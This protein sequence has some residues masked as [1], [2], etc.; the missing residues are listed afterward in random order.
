MQIDVNIK[1]TCK[2]STD[3]AFQYA[4]PMNVCTRVR[5]FLNVYE[6]ASRYEECPNVLEECS[7]KYV[8]WGTLDPHVASRNTRVA[9]VMN[10]YGIVHPCTS[11]VFVRKCLI[12]TKCEILSLYNI[13]VLHVQF[14]H[15]V[16][17]YFFFFF[18][19]ISRY[20]AKV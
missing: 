14:T 4:S 5:A 20:R 15:D 17:F 11:A 6:R 13:N 3:S 18:I 10:V 12:F 9:V 16:S 1:T 8:Y 7:Y 19:R 2:S